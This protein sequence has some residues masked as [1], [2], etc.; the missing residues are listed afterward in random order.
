MFSLWTYSTPVSEISVSSAR[1]IINKLSWPKNTCKILSGSSASNRFSISSI[2]T[3][4]GSLEPADWQ[5]WVNNIE[6]ACKPDPPQL[7]DRLRELTGV[8]FEA[9]GIKEGQQLTCD[10]FVKG[11]SEFAVQE[12][13]KKERGEIPIL[14]PMND[15]SIGGYSKPATSLRVLLTKRLRLPTQ[16]TMESLTGKSWIT[17]SSSFGL[18]LDPLVKKPQSFLD[19]H[20]RPIKAK[21]C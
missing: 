14:Y 4:N 9:I 2:T 11:F 20:L 10:E 18:R 7:I 21:S 19:K 17:T 5:L 3:K 13:A 12:H 15:R 8:Y 6:K 16:I 1:Q